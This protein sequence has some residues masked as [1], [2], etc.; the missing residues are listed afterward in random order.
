MFNKA[1]IAGR[2]GKLDSK[3]LSNGTQIMNI[4]LATSKKVLT[5]TGAREHKTTWH[6]VVAFN[7]TADLISNYCAVGDTILVEGEIEHQEYTTQAGEKRTATKILC[8]SV[9]FLPKA[10]AEKSARVTDEKL[11][12]EDSDVPF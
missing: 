1:I 3:V 2:I 4:S 11:P 6:N 9:T 8:S 5:N 12:F 10:Q 7:K